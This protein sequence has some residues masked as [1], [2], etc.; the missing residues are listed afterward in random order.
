MNGSQCVIPIS[1]KKGG[2]KRYFREGK[3]GNPEESVGQRG[4]GGIINPLMCQM[5]F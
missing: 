4:G 3:G 2:E 5:N 1:Q